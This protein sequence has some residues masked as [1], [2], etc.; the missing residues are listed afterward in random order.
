MD[1][2]GLW[3]LRCSLGSFLILGDLMMVT[4]SGIAFVRRNV[5]PTAPEKPTTDAVY[6]SSLA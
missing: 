5:V 1:S 3:S 4:R 2:W 6:S